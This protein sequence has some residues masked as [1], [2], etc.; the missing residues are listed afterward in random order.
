M[1]LL[2]SLKSVLFANDLPP[3]PKRQMLNIANDSAYTSE[4]L[5]G[6]LTAATYYSQYWTKTD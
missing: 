5:L 4:E 1:A 2:L 3:S 6:T